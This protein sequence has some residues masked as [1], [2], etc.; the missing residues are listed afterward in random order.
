MSFSTSIVAR[1][2]PIDSNRDSRWN[3][4]RIEDDERRGEKN[5]QPVGRCAGVRPDTSSS[6]LH[7][8]LPRWPSSCHLHL[9]EVAQRSTPFDIDRTSK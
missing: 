3:T 1:S 8:A 2:K 6:E 7:A 4:R 5:V 9:H